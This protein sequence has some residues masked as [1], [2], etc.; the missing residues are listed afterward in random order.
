[1]L[2]SCPAVSVKHVRRI[3]S[4]AYM[5]N[6]GEIIGRQV[7]N[8]KQDEVGDDAATAVGARFWQTL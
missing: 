5:G 7:Q 6:K 4:E 8:G 1:M 3:G 2:K